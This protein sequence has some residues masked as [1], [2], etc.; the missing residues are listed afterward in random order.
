MDR[1]AW[2]H[3][4]GRKELAMT[5]Q[6]TLSFFIYTHTHIHTHIYT[7]I[8]FSLVQS[9]SCVRIFATPWTVARQASLSIINS[10]SLLK[11]MFMESGM[12][13]NYLILCRSLLLPPSIFPSIRIFSN[14]SGNDFTSGGQ[15][16]GVLAS[17]SVLPR[18]TQD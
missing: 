4:W 14:N 15:N 16:I 7:H 9:L 2:C 6:L 17:T 18:N 3:P 10:Q 13:S 12:P 11:L 1:G 5:E 8:Q